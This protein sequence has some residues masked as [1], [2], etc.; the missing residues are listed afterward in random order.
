MSIPPY[1]TVTIT[2]DTVGAQNAGF[3]VGAFLTY[4]S[5]F[6]ERSLT[7]SGYA[8]TLETFA[9]SS[10]EAL[11]ALGYFGQDRKPEELKFIRGILPPTLR[12]AGLLPAAP[13]VGTPIT[14]TAGGE[15]VTETDISVTPLADVVISAVANAS[16]TFTS[17]AHGMATGD[18]PYRLTNSGGALPTG[19]AVD[20]NYW[21]IKLTAD[22][23]QLASSYANAIALTPV[24]ITSD[25]TGTHTVQRDANDVMVAQIVDRLNS[26]VGKNFTAAQSAGAGDTDTF[27]VTANAAGG[28]FYLTAD[29][30][31][32]LEFAL[33]HA[34][35][36]VATDLA[37]IVVEDD[38]W[39]MLF[40]AYNS[41]A[42]VLAAAAWIETQKKQYA[43]D[44]VESDTVTA[45]VLSSDTADDL[46]TLAYARTSTWYHNDPS[47][48]LAG[49]IAGR[50]LPIDPG[51]ET[52]A[53]KNLSGIAAV[54][55]FTST[56]RTNLENKKANS[57]RTVGGA[58]RTFDGYT[59]DGDYI[60]VQRGLDWLEDDMS[61]AVFNALATADKVPYT[62]RGV[63]VVEAA[64]RGSL[65][66]AVRAGVLSESPAPVVTV[67]LVADVSS[68]N[69]AARV[70]PD[71]KFSGT[72]AGAIHKVTINGTVSV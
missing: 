60:D 12:Y 56:H 36:G 28:W 1:V 39:Y 14:L 68:A 54:T 42:Y 38:D 21:I 5:E 22:T 19:T 62:D 2:R 4:S 72:L 67:P 55:P 66:R 52:W 44:L 9:E 29:N 35:P 18:G 33:N 25:G 11:F 59:V 61:V 63:A 69:K 8:E 20:T 32:L 64:V 41:N 10:P 65:Q 23:F 24:T 43:A 37:N 27:T 46:H 51:G 58:G 50:V 71:V 7:V 53:L 47:A 49:R 40:T 17:V 13:V 26:V 57:Y 31:A 48:F 70:L 45:A 30:P 3:G 16:E 15:G 6:S 34:D